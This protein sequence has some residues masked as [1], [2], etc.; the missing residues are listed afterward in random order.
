MTSLRVAKSKVALL[1]GAQDTHIKRAQQY[2]VG[3]NIRSEEI[4]AVWCESPENI[5]AASLIYLPHLC[6]RSPCL[7]ANY[8]VSKKPCVRRDNLR[9]RPQESVL[10]C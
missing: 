4:I 7:L 6:C 3:N 8:P 9:A 1:S 5:Q 10:Y 2:L